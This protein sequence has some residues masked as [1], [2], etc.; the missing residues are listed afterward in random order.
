MVFSRGMAAHQRERP[1]R[2]LTHPTH[3]KA[4]AVAIDPWA[5]VLPHLSAPYHNR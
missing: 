1:M 5:G 4:L 2:N 3:V